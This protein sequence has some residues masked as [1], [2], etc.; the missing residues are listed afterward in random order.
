M[1]GDRQSKKRDNNSR[2]ET[3]KRVINTSEKS[4]YINERKLNYCLNML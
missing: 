3:E 1:D 4:S 2:I